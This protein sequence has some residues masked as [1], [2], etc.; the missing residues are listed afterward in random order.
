MQP[1]ATSERRPSLRIRQLPLRV[2][3]QPSMAPAL[4]VLVD[5]ELDGR[6]AGRSG[7]AELREGRGPEGEGG[8][9]NFGWLQ[10]NMGDA[11]SAGSSGELNTR[12]IGRRTSHTLQLIRG[13][14]HIGNTSENTQE[15]F[16]FWSQTERGQRYSDL[17]VIE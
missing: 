14:I 4:E 17:F 13:R 11:V 2:P 7:R 10:A 1:S 8:G 16:C 5:R 15:A 12:N 6:I 9:R 3:S